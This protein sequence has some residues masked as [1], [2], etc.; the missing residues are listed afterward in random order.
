MKQKLMWLVLLLAG[1][2]VTS[3]AQVRSKQKPLVAENGI[4]RIVVSDNIDVLLIQSADGAAWVR[5]PDN[6][7]GKVKVSVVDENLYLSAVHGLPQGERLQVYIQVE[8]LNM[9]VLQDVATAV[10]RGVLSMQRLEVIV[11]ENARA[12]LRTT[13]DV[14]VVKH[15]KYAITKE[16]DH[17]LVY[18]AD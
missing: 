13:G 4:R 12:I 14:H 6:T 10:S 11:A 5:V 8:E 16:N 7:L 15:G 18:A 3:F 9:L 1:I 17:S 2:Q